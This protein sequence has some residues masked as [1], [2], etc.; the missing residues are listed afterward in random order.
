M[1]DTTEIQFTQQGYRQLVK[2]LREARPSEAP[3]P[4]PEPLNAMVSDGE[5]AY[6]DPQG[7][8]RWVRL[9]R[10]TDVPDT[11]RPLLVGRSRREQG[12]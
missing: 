12:T 7:L 8:L 1:G 10:A 2:A 5:A 6:L 11:W 9:D 4:E 3:A